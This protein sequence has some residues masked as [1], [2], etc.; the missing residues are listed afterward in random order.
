MVVATRVVATIVGALL[1]ALATPLAAVDSSASPSNAA[2]S[3]T[4]KCNRSFNDRP[5]ARDVNVPLNQGRHPAHLPVALDWC[6]R[7]FCTSSWNQHIPQYCGSCFAH[8][9]L[10]SANDRIKIMNHKLYGYHGP[11]VMLGRQSF[12]N[13]APGH[14]LS[15]G[16]MGGE[17]ADVYEFMRVYGLPDETC[18][19]YNATDYS[20]YLNTSNGTCMYTPES[21]DVATC[22]PVTNVVRYRATTYGRIV[23]EDAMLEELQRG[24]ITCGIA[25]SPEFDWNYTAG[26]FWD[27][28]NYS[29]V[30]HDVEV[31]GYGEA[32]GVKYWHVRNSWGS[33]WGENGFFKIVRGVNNL[34]IESDC[35][36]VNVDVGDETLVWETK[37]HNG[38]RTGGPAYGGSIYGIKPYTNAS[39]GPH[40]RAVT[41]WTTDGTVLDNTTL[42]S[43]ERNQADEAK[44]DGKA[45][46]MEDVDDDDG[47]IQKPMDAPTQEA[48]AVHLAGKYD[49][50]WSV[51]AVG[52]VGVGVVAA[53]VGVAVATKR[54]QAKYMSLA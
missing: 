36:Y 16:C 25:C 24:P 3:K 49:V 20:K 41:N 13:C 31:V 2:K 46:G 42:I 30:D 17:P 38:T 12:L 53:V 45:D 40:D 5:H 14:G 48:E 1:L 4:C 44:D 9:S 33:Y 18:L 47:V 51:N 15:Q 10:S 11:D 7:G 34:M 6:E 8:G 50:H 22:F 43:H 29:D 21:P 19:P 52:V 28:T 37:N 27:K 39:Y 35:H 32:D 23:G 54:R 26:I